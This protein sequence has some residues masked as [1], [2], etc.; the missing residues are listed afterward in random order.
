MSSKS[1]T[2]APLGGKP[3]DAQAARV[4][5]ANG[6]K[7]AA[8]EPAEAPHPAVKK[9]GKA[10]P[11]VGGGANGAAPT[12]AA[13]VAPTA[14][15]TKAAAKAAAAATA[16]V[17]NA[18]SSSSG[19]T[20]A[21]D[22]HDESKKKRHQLTHV[23]GLD[24]SQARVSA[25]LKAH[26]SNKSTADETKKL[27]QEIK[28]L[29]EQKLA[30]AD[31]DKLIAD[32]KANQAKLAER[33]EKKPGNNK[34][35]AS[36]ANIGRRIVELTALRAKLAAAPADVAAVDAQLALK[37][38]EVEEMDKV[39]RLS[40]DASIVTTAAIDYV[41]K[42]LIRH[43]FQQAQAAGS[44]C[45]EVNHVHMGAVEKLSVYPLV[46]NLHEFRTYTPE[47]EKEIERLQTE[48]NKRVK[49]QRE[50]KKAK[51]AGTAGATA[52]AKAG[53]DAAPTGA[54]AATTAGGK[55]AATGAPAPAPAPFG[56]THDEDEDELHETTF[57]TY[58]DNAIRSVKK[59][60]ENYNGIR[61]STRA[62]E[63]GSELITQFIKNMADLAEI[64]VRDMVKSRTLNAN[65]IIAILRMIL[66][67]E[68]R[69]AEE[70]DAF[71]EF[72]DQNL[73]KYNTHSESEKARKVASMD[74]DK[75]REL[76]ASLREKEVVRKRK[77]L[78]SAQKRAAESA[79]AAQRLAD[80]IGGAPPFGA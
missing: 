77:A 18:A 27:R 55:K 61:I 17:A 14:A 32:M 79:A 38:K 37:K 64:V 39:V 1:K 42:D 23:L 69:S 22:A 36:G 59:D 33:K 52:G 76:E 62:R 16:A 43:G 31:I 28:R 6:V 2:T 78:E 51:A 74:A 9:A 54:A 7:A 71:M 24:I 65:H 45:F 46:H 53:G 21:D 5:A 3:G 44:R 58:V 13:A 70:I 80:E 11:A 56:A 57:Y 49:E 29:E 10:T 15:Q 40:H 67:N 12:G 68:N 8:T 4:H 20:G 35:L 63:Y 75:Q 25:H 30:P 26:F 73:V 19:A 72:L 48:E 47:G 66:V 34:G 50:A 60:D 41:I